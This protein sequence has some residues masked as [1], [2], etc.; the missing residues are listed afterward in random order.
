[1]LQEKALRSIEIIDSTLQQISCENIIKV[2][3]LNLDCIEKSYILNQYLMQ[4]IHEENEAH[5][6]FIMNVCT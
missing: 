1:M 4:S 3:E 2:Y 6:R 5:V